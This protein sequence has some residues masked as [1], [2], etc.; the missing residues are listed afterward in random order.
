M[1][2]RSF[3]RKRFG[4]QSVNWSQTLLKSARQR[5][6]STAP[7]IWDKRSWKMLFLV[8]SK[9]SGLFDNTLTTSKKYSRHSRDNFLQE[10]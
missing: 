10:I 7:L 4:N 5:F 6:Y 8:R 9:I 1:S 3:F 2:K